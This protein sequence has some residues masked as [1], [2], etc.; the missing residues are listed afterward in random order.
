V[1]HFAVRGNA[2]REQGT[3]LRLRS[4]VPGLHADKATAKIKQLCNGI[5]VFWPKAEV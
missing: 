3:E 5:A 2:N 1:E 4:A